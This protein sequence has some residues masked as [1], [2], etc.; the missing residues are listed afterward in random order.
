MS[1]S[2]HEP[3]EAHSVIPTKEESHTDTK[4]QTQIPES[5]P[6]PGADFVFLHKKLLMKIHLTKWY[7]QILIVLLT[8]FICADTLGSPDSIAFQVSAGIPALAVTVS[9]IIGIVRLFK[10]QYLDGV[11]QIIVSAGIGFAGLLFLSVHVMFYPVDGFAKNLTIPN[12]IKLY[13]PKD[14][15][16]TTPRKNLDF[17]LYNGMQPGMYDWDIPVGGL[18]Q[19]TI[20]LKAFEVTKGTPLSAESLKRDTSM[21]VHISKPFKTY[22]LAHDFM[23][24]EGDWGDYYAARFEL[25]YLPA[26]GGK[27]R[28]LVEKIYRIEGWMR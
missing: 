27:E 20:Y 15:I 23:I 17:E 11:F 2:K 3:V 12:N 26:N 25:W 1:L 28:K 22:R 6:K 18:Q 7:I 14:S 10:K 13:I 19:G 21:Y 24:N 5:V 4:S 16:R 9:G 8:C